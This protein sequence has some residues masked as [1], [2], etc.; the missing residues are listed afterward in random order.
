MP[1]CF[2]SFLAI[3]LIFCV[4]G[5]VPAAYPQSGAK[6]GEWRTY[7]GDLGYTRYAPLDQIDASNFNRLEVAWRFKTD[8]L[9]PRPEYQYEGTPL[10]V[11]GKLYVTAGSRRAVVCLDAAT[12]ELIWMHSENEGVRAENA[13]RQFSGHGVSYWTDG[14]DER[15]L[16]VTIG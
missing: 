10:M 7:G 1:R 11:K 15:I 16:Y 4:A 2:R 5:I 12:G 9:G 13:P 8:M 14:K 3:V 6:D